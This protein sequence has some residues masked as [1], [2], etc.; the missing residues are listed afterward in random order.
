PNAPPDNMPVPTFT[1]EF[2]DLGEHLIPKLQACVR[3]SNFTGKLSVKDFR[4]APT[5]LT[6]AVRPLE[7]P[8]FDA[9]FEIVHRLDEGVW[10]LFSHPVK[11]FQLPDLANITKPPGDAEQ[12]LEDLYQNLPEKPSPYHITPLS[13]PIAQKLQSLFPPGSEVAQLGDIP[14][15]STL[16]GHVGEAASGTCFHHED[17]GLRS[18]NLTLFGWKIWIRISLHHT[19]KFEALVQR[20]TNCDNRCD[21]FVRHTS[22]VIPPSRL[23]AENIDFIVFCSGPGEMVLTEPGQYHAVINWTRCGAIAINFT[24]PGEDPIPRKLSVCD[25]DGL[26][27]LRHPRIQQL[28]SAKRKE[29][30]SRPERP[31]PNKRPRSDNRT[32]KVLVDETTSRDALLRFMATVCA[33]RK[34]RNDLRGQLSQI[35]TYDRSD[36]PAALDTLRTTC[37]HNSQLFSFLEILTSV[38]LVRNVDRRISAI[39]PKAIDTLLGHRGLEDIRQNRRSIQKEL[40]G[41]EKWDLL[42]GETSS[43]TYEGILCFVPPVFKDYRVM[44]RSQIQELSKD[45]I[46]SFRSALGRVEHAQ[47]LCEVGRAFQSQIFG[48]TEFPRRRFEELSDRELST[49][50]LSG[51]LELLEAG[52]RDSPAGRDRPTGN[53]RPA[54]IDRAR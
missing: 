18:Y 33:W 53:G 5:Q 43:Y 30:G 54:G 52:G 23:R 9:Q 35:S 10:Q 49:L 21:Q 39:A 40:A 31:I 16:F 3:D 46:A 27:P 26:Y 47:Y 29:H 37:G 17:G 50:S 13:G 38:H 19:A 32:V 12:Y 14:G 7:M 44:T 8:G 28:H 4:L 6:D 41:Y 1:L 45:D 2:S 36:R 51:L 20:L 34:V 42:C 22:V 15:V 48:L 25:L 24:L 11:E